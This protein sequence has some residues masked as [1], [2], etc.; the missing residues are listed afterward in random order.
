MMSSFIQLS[1][2]LFIVLF[3]STI[4]RILKQPLIVGYILCGILLGPSFL[5]TV[6]NN[7]IILT[8]SEI[9]VSFLLFLVGMYLNPKKIKEFG[10]ISLITGI[11]QFVFT[12]LIGYFIS[13]LLN[14]SIL[15]S[16]YVSIALTFSSTII[17]TKLLS[18]KESLDKLY[19]KISIGFLLVQDLIAMFLLIFLSSYSE[20]TTSLIFFYKMIIRGILIILIIIPISIFVINK[21]SQFFAKSQELL[22]IFAISFGLLFSS[23]FFY[24]G[25]SIE[26]GALVAGIIISTSPYSYEISSRLKPLRDFFIISFFIVLGSKMT[27]PNLS[28]HI[29]PIIIFSFF[30]LIGNPLIVMILMGIFGYS[31]NTSFMC[32]LT[33]AQISEFSLVLISLGVKLGHISEDILSLVTAVGLITILCSTYL[34]IYS[35]KIYFKISKYLSV[36]ERKRIREIQYKDKEKKYEYILLG[37]NRIGFSIM[38]YFINSNKNYLIVDFNPERITRLKKQGINCIYGDVSNVEFLDNLNLKNAKLVV[39]TIPEKEISLLILERTK[40]KNKNIVVI[41][42]ARQIREALELYKEGADYVILPHFL[43]GEYTSQLI[44]RYN[45]NLKKYEEEKIKH[46]KELKKRLIEKQEHPYTERD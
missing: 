13:R 12:S 20:Q 39:S 46:I 15:T 3:I 45:I 18:D 2:I 7:E 30:I 4:L 38:N 25:F 42:T 41:L 9:G 24:L 8:F 40:K 23:L 27:L 17:I 1:L 26:V 5:N 35:E 34:I 10:K 28:V 22:F 29:I 16:I 43:G 36:F 14:F 44:S 21:F 33:V 19:G 37:E 11:G 32:G 6:K 31:R